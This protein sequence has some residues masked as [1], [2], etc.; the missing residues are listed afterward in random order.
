[1]PDGCVSFATYCGKMYSRRLV[2][3]SEFCYEIR[4]VKHHVYGKRQTAEMTTWPC[5]D[6][7]FAARCF[8]FLS[9]L[10]VL[11]YN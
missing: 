6:P 8:Q 3:Y 5:S 9:K 11:R 1:M 10:S 4:E 2:L 7:S